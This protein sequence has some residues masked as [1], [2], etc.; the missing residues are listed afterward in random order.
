MTKLVALLLMCLTVAGCQGCSF[1]YKRAGWDTGGDPDAAYAQGLMRQ[2]VEL[3]VNGTSL[4]PDLESKEPK[5]KTM[6]FG[7]QGSGT[8]IAKR[9]KGK[10][11]ESLILTAD[12]LCQV[13]KKET[14]EFPITKDIKVEAPV[15]GMEIVVYSIDMEKMEAEIVHEDTA[16]DLCV[17]KVAGDAGDPATVASGPP[18]IGAFVQHLGAPKDNYSY[19]MAMV[20]DGRYCGT[21]PVSK[22]NIW[23]ETYAAFSAGGSSGG[24]IYY[25]GKLVGTLVRADPYFGHPVYGVPLP[26]VRAEIEA[27]RRAW[28]GQPSTKTSAGK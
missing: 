11:A 26:F 12:H 14:V 18:P 9:G 10:Q 15:L 27:G 24:G 8:V 22:E 25:H 5:L 4:V 1:H 3:F 13:A 19:H 7:A 6:K 20:F 28:L 21:Q 17:M 23:L 16:N 2:T